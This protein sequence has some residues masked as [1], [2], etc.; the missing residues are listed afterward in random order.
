MKTLN[1]RS[2]ITLLVV[3]AAIPALAFTIYS[4]WDER[5]RAEVNARQELQHLATLAAQRQEQVIKGTEQTLEAIALVPSS[6]L[7]D[8]ARCNE[9]LAK[10]LRRSLEIY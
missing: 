7:F 5:K 2:R 1:T 9:Y 8:Q 6:V 4:S 3:A 10:L